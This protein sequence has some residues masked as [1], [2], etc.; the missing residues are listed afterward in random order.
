MKSKQ[1]KYSH[2]T[3]AYNYSSMNMK[4]LRFSVLT[5]I[6]ATIKEPNITT[7]T[8]IDTGSKVTLFATS[9][10]LDGKNFPLI[11]ELILKEFILHQRT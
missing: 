4:Q 6:E 7:T 10:C 1:H 2:Q 11:K 8:L 5:Y 3:S 9:Y